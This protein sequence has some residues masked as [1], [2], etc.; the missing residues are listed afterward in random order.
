MAKPGHGAGKT[1]FTA[2][3]G[4]YLA[5]IHTYTLL[6]RQ[7][8]AEMDM[9]R[10]FGVTP[11]AVHSMVV[12][13]TARGLVARTPGK[14]RSLRV[15]VPSANLPALRDPAGEAEDGAAQQG[16]EADER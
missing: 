11:P 9:Q 14:A 16:D 12:T 7:P 15:L 13:L 10:F 1:R 6:H 3:Q 4:Q 2:L 8:P 5:Y